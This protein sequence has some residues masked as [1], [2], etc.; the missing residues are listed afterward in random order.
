MS[1]KTITLLGVLAAAVAL[2]LASVAGSAQARP[3]PASSP[4]P[5]A[6]S[7]PSSS[8]HGFRKVDSALGIKVTYGPIGSGGGITQITNRTVDFGASDAPLTPDQFAACK[9]CVQIPWALSATSIPYKARRRAEPD[10]PPA[11]GPVI[12]NIFLGKIKKWNDPA[13]K[14]AEQGQEHPEHRRSRSST[15]ATA[16]GTTYNFTDYLNQRQPEWKSNG[17]EGHVPSTGRRRR[18]PR[19]GRRLGAR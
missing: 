10:P 11:P 4:A 2:V 1:R 16:A 3:R 7:S 19:L 13:I 8:R 18:R 15:A 12:A 9:G 17:R 5:A 6:R 14:S